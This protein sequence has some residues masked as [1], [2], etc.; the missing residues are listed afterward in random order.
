RTIDVERGAHLATA[1]E[2]ALPS[3]AEPP[4]PRIGDVLAIEAQRGLDGV[5]DRHAR[6]HALEPAE[7]GEQRSERDQHAEIGAD[8]AR[9]KAGETLTLELERAAEAP[10][11][12]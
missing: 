12:A 5:P 3:E 1:G 11:L 2:R 9:G 10:R 6:G 8:R 7:A 4:Q